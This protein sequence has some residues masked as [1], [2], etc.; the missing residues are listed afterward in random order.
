M[1]KRTTK[2]QSKKEY[3]L[4]E[5]KAWLEGIEEMQPANWAPTEAQW[6]TIREKLMNIVEEVVEVEVPA[7]VQ[8]QQ[9]VR[10]AGPPMVRQAPPTAPAPAPIPMNPPPTALPESSALPAQ[11]EMTPAAAA[12]LQGNLPSEMVP[13]AAGKTRTSNIDTSDGNYESSFG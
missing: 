5:F 10:P 12:A 8:P 9:V 3:T 1:A 2:R 4:T 11:P 7:A 13:D 6:K